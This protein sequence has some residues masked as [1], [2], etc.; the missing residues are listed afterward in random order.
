MGVSKLSAT[1][2]TTSIADIDITG[3]AS[4]NILSLNADQRTLINL[5]GTAKLSIGK[6]ITEDFAHEASSSTHVGIGNATI[7]TAYVAAYGASIAKIQ[8][9][10]IKTLN[11]KLAGGAQFDI[12][13]GQGL[14]TNLITSGNGKFR[15]FEFNP[16]ILNK[17]LL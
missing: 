8:T 6:L 4:M 3:S 5:A 2:I 16:G 7:H 15:M 11:L 9:L 13:K 10:N 14:K 12:Q 1:N 17:E